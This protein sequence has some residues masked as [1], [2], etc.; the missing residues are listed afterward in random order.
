M[1]VCVCVCLSVNMCMSLY[2]SAYIL[3]VVK[4]RKDPINPGL[5][6]CAKSAGK[7]ISYAY[8]KEDSGGRYAFN[9]EIMKPHLDWKFR[10]ENKEGG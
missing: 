5:N 3:G 4:K 7:E 6:K 8:G 9:L 2:I 1:N 10:Y